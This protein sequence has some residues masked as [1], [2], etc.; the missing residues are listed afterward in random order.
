MNSPR[1]GDSAK[2][3]R[4]VLTGDSQ[5]IAFDGIGKIVVSISEQLT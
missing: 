2:I 4:F 5:T 3:A 1:A